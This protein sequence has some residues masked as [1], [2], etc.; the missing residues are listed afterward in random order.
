MIEVGLLVRIRQVF[1]VRLVVVW[2]VG[3]AAV[4]TV[5]GVVPL[6]VDRVRIAGL[7]AAAVGLLLR[8]SLADGKLR[9]RFLV[10]RDERY[11]DGVGG[12]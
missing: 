7:G 3:A 5:A 10:R 2:T 6:L 4:A 12:G 1:L 11:L 9:G 8:V